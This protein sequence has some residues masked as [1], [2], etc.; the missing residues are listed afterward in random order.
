M[1]INKTVQRHYFDTLLY[2]NEIGDW[3]F[4]LNSMYSHTNGA[5]SASIACIKQTAAVL[6]EAGVHSRKSN[7]RWR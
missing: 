2:Q 5:S 4:R 7:T 1:K 6:N 3:P